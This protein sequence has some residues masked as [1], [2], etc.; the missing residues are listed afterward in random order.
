MG[1]SVDDER[2]FGGLFEEHR[3]AVLGYALRR[4]A[5][6][7]DAADVVAETF[8][9]AWRR[10]EDV[11]RGEAERPWLLG[12]AR[13]V[14]AN[15][16]RGARRHAGL[17]ERLAADLATQVAA[18]EP[19]A[20]HEHGL[21]AALARLPGDDRELLLLVAWE[22]LTPAQIAVVTGARGVT[23]RARLHRARRR[24]RAEL[25][26]APTATTFDLAKEQL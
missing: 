17:T 19:A 8:L 9:T 20:E 1:N 6:P 15:Q 25:D 7:A 5:D 23:V 21:S 26:G 24:L 13:R 10:L 3:R 2:R 18:L 4:V 16:R 22:G 11:P 12:V 14:L